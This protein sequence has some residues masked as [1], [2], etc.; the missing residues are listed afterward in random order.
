[1]IEIWRQRAAVHLGKAAG[2]P[3]L[4]RE[5][6][7]AF[8]AA[9]R[10]FDV[11]ALRRHRSQRETQR[12]RAVSVDQVQR[13]DDVALRLRHLR[14]LLVADEGVD[15]DRRER[16]FLH[17]VHA[18]HH[19]PGDPEE[20]DVEAGHQHVGR[21]IARHIGVVVGPAKRRE[22]PQ[23]RRK[24]RIEHVFV[25]RN[26]T[27][28]FGRIARHVRALLRRDDFLF[29]IIAERAADGLVL[30]LGDEHL[31]VRAIPGRDL[32]TPPQL[33]RDTPGLDVLHPL[34]IGFFPIF[35]HKA[36]RAGAHGSNRRLRHRLRVDIPLIG[37]IRLDDDAGSIAV[38]HGMGVRFDPFEEAEILKPL[39]DQL[40]CG[41]ALHAVQLVDKL[42]RAFGQTA[43]IVFVIG[44]RELAFDI[45]NV[46]LRQVVAA[47]DFKIVEV[48]RR[49]NLHRAGALFH[50][51]VIIRYDRNETTDQRQHHVLANQ[52]TIAIVGSVHRDRAVA[53]HRFG[54][55]RRHHD[56]GRCILRIEG[57]AFERIAQMPQA[58]LHLDLL[59]FKIGDRGQ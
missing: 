24:P 55:R 12:V 44:K 14:A 47:A 17:E 2:V 27:I 49:R 41:E 18:H 33:P 1:M 3:E 34:E 57:H 32:M 51:G 43:Q 37:Q 30:G 29:D 8:D 10:E 21:I 19:H 46:D 25:A 48:M 6:A 26:K 42:L 11:A 13:I 4:G 54:A 9:G 20:D 28:A 40:S 16:R 56:I 50:I 35:G 53:E 22:R 31:A 38:R 58:A 45:E 39:Y 52:M 5:I 15:I 7:I 23:R 36:G 59:H